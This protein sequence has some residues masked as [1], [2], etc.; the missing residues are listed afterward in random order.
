MCNLLNYPIYLE[1]SAAQ[2][3]SL[4]AADIHDSAVVGI[5]SFLLWGF[6]LNLQ[7]KWKKTTKIYANLQ[8][9]TVK[10]TNVIFEFLL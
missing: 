1:L 10:I 3:F 6:Q 2:H 9:K 8:V 7:V 4:P 5:E